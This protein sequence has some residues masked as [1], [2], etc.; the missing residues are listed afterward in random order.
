MHPFQWLFDHVCDPIVKVWT[1][2]NR[3]RSK[4]IALLKHTYKDPPWWLGLLK[5]VIT[6]LVMLSG[7]YFAWQ[8]AKWT[9]KTLLVADKQYCVSDV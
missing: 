7:L 8:G 4:G 9:Y 5:S 6:W 2:I 3:Y 1:K